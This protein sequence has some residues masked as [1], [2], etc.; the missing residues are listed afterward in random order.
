MEHLE[1]LADLLP[2]YYA[3]L[4]PFP[5]YYRWLSYGNGNSTG[6]FDTQIIISG[7]LH[8]TF[9]VIDMIIKMIILLQ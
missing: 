9:F 8:R 4:F 5:D 1:H 7:F 3:R 2:T 6:L